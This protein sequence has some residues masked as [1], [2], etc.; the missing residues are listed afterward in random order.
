MALALADWEQPLVER[1]RAAL[2]PSG[3]FRAHIPSDTR[4]RR[5]Y[6]ICERVIRQHSRSFYLASMLLP[7]PKRKA[8]RALYALCRVADDIVDMPR[9]DPEAELTRW[10]RIIHADPPPDDEPV[11]LAWADTRIRYRIPATYVEQLLDALSQDLRQTRYETFAELAAYCYGVASTVGLM[12]M[13]II[14]FSDSEIIPYAIRLGVA[15]QLTNILRDVGEDWKR[16]RLYLPQ[17]ELRAFRLTED[18]IAIG[19]VDGRWRDFMRF[20]IAR[21]RRLYAE[22]LPGVMGLNPDGR[23]A[24]AAAAELYRGILEDIEAHDYDVFRR[25]AHLSLGAMLTR[26]PRIWWRVRIGFYARLTVT[27]YPSDQ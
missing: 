14:G 5:A 20:Q 25:R 27:T 3:S 16:Q 24:I 10:R 6:E 9:G 2:N 21:V 18:D 8:V 13:H 23:L 26:L 1:A 17:E 4:L 15:L 7:A 19:R 12:S 22:A 11:A